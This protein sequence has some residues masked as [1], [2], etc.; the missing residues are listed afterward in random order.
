MQRLYIKRFFTMPYYA[1]RKGRKIGI[2]H[3]W[4][5]CREQVNGFAGARYKK[6]SS[7]A[8][9]QNFI[10]AEDNKPGSS[11]GLTG[12][13]SNNQK[14]K[15]GSSQYSFNT[16]HPLSAKDSSDIPVYPHGK[17]V[18][19][20][21]AQTKFSKPCT[22]IV[23]QGV[24]RMYCTDNPSENNGDDDEKLNK[25][26]RLVA[27]FL[28][29]FDSSAQST[30][31]PGSSLDASSSVSSPVKSRQKYITVYTDGA[32]ENNGRCGATAGIGVYWGDD[33]PWNVSEPLLGRQTNNRAEIHAACRAVKIAR[34]NGIKKLIV[35]TD[36]QFVINAMKGWVHKWQKN[37]WKL[38]TGGPVINKEDFV[39][40]LQESQG[41]KIKWQHVRGHSG[42][43]AN[44]KADSLAVQGVRKHPNI[45]R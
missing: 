44:E 19:L 18:S 39:E 25:R 9:A 26:R 17:H 15:K 32:C 33:H 10:V 38:A 36:S 16:K 41:I 34:Q 27:E 13:S 28:D 6:F 29:D 22:Q 4:E 3:D 1:V 11:G 37:G 24:K 5:S 21:G 43:P 12:C 30:I 45:N 23:G 40:L 2:F 8:E 20:V 14:G 31:S 7:E 42:N 35:Y